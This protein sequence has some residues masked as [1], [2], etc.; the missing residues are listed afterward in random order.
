M[1]LSICAALT[2]D[3]AASGTEFCFRARP[4]SDRLEM[5]SL[6]TSNPVAMYFNCRGHP[7]GPGPIGNGI[8]TDFES[9]G[10]PVRP[11]VKTAA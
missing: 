3:F 4:A 11:T 6:T 5:Q 8:Q 2:S 10:N 9:I 1:N 7:G